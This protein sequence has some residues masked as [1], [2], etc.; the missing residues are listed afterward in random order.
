MMNTELITE[1]LPLDNGYVFYEI[2]FIVIY[3]SLQDKQGRTTKKLPCGLHIVR[4]ILVITKKQ[5]R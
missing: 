1:T 5:W 2:V 4:F 3:F